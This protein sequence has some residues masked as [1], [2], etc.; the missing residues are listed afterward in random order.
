MMYVPE[1]IVLKPGC[2]RSNV[3]AGQRGPGPN[4]PSTRDGVT[5]PG[6]SPPSDADG[7][8]KMLTSTWRLMLCKILH[9]QGQI[10]LFAPLT[11]CDSDINW[12]S[13]ELRVFY[14]KSKAEHTDRKTLSVNVQP[15]HRSVRIQAHVWQ[16]PSAKTL[17]HVLWLFLIFPI[18]VWFLL[19]HLCVV[20]LKSLSL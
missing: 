11:F 12:M 16:K 8:V 2:S 5:G 13:G 10:L 18:N 6:V 15:C 19:S 17:K 9:H 20:G 3:S 14:S 7:K 1:V 4:R